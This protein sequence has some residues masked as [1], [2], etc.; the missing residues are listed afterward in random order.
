MAKA[1]VEGM[2]AHLIS[3][4][5]RERQLHVCVFSVRVRPGLESWP[6]GYEHLV[7]F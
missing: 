5:R 6:T 4:L 2:G 7:L 3:G 1:L